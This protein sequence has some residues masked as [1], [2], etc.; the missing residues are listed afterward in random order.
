MSF[1]SCMARAMSAQKQVDNLHP[2]VTMTPFGAKIIKQCRETYKEALKEALS[3]EPEPWDPNAK[4]KKFSL[5][6][7]KSYEAWQAEYQ[8]A[9]VPKTK[10]NVNAPEHRIDIPG[11]DVYYARVIFPKGEG[12]SIAQGKRRGLIMFSRAVVVNML[13]R[14]K[15]DWE[16]RDDV[17]MSFTPM[18][19]FTLRPG[20]KKARGHTVVAGLGMGYQLIQVTRKKTV[21]EVT[22]VEIDKD[23]VK[24]VKPRIKGKL[25]GCKV[26]WVVGDAK[27]VLPTLTADVALVDIFR[28]YGGNWFAPKCPNIKTIWV[29][30]AA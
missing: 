18:E 26:N 6:D 29:W 15:R 22:V 10:C 9:D 24:W 27:D 4:F 25:G 17:W 11:T 28:D 2:F 5:I 3:Y 20:I 21:K 1:E 13:R 7:A 19:V 8:L 23:L 30:G 16:R 14:H 12:L